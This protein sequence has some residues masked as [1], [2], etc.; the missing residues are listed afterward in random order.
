MVLIWVF[1][2]KFFFR[3][4]L[5]LL[6][7]VNCV[8]FLFEVFI[9]LCVLV[10]VLIFVVFLLFWRVVF[11]FLNEMDELGRESIENFL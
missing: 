5:W 6:W 8:V 3:E 11:S 10:G 2:L 7:S 1:L 4:Y 9:E